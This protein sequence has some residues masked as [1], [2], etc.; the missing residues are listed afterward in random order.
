MPV[1]ASTYQIDPSHVSITFEFVTNRL[2]CDPGDGD[3]PPMVYRTALEQAR[4]LLALQ[5]QNEAGPQQ[6]P[7]SEI[8][9]QGVGVLDLA[10]GYDAISEVIAAGAPAKFLKNL[11]SAL[12]SRGVPIIGFARPALEAEPSLAV[13]ESA[14]HAA[15]L[16]YMNSDLDTL[17]SD[18]VLDFAVAVC[19]SAGFPVPS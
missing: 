5:A 6:P 2:S 18:V 9:T 12:V 14:L 16:G 10:E 15:C 4:D 1:S 13:I 3:A 8:C 7:A 11:T 19:Q 17:T